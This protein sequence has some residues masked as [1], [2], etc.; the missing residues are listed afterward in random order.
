MKQSKRELAHK[1]HLSKASTKQGKFRAGATE[2]GPVQQYYRPQYE[3]QRHNYYG[4]VL[5]MVE[6]YARQKRYK[7]VYSPIHFVLKME[8]YYL[9]GRELAEQ[10][11]DIVESPLYA[12]M[13]EGKPTP[14]DNLW[15]EEVTGGVVFQ[16]PGPWLVSGNYVTFTNGASIKIVP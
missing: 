2:Y 11:V 15:W 1:K 14:N 16:N 10:A 5:I 9:N 6:E 3:P 13:N 12:A 8:S 4:D 7:S